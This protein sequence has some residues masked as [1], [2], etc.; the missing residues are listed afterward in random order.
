MSDGSSTVS[1]VLRAA[2]NPLRNGGDA[3]VCSHDKNDGF[4]A[5]DASQSA[6]RKTDSNDNHTRFGE[7][8]EKQ[9]YRQRPATFGTQAAELRQGFV[10]AV[11]PPAK[12]M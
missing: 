8:D 4:E 3:P 10:C 6:E 11:P 12:L 1:A 5:H 7:Q 2:K 9:N